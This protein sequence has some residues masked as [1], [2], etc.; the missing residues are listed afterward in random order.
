MIV[1]FDALTTPVEVPSTVIDAVAPVPFVL[2]VF[3]ASILAAPLIADF[4]APY[5]VNTAARN[6]IILSGI[7]TLLSYLR[8]TYQSVGASKLLHLVFIF[9]NCCVF[10][11]AKVLSVAFVIVSVTLLP[12]LS[13]A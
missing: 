4:D 10:T 11:S 9:I 3:N 7:A 6:A 2:T 5:T 1:L 12:S 8:V 13:I